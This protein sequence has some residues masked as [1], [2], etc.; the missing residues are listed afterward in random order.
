MICVLLY[1]TSGSFFKSLGWF[2]KIYESVMLVLVF[3]LVFHFFKK[4]GFKVSPNP[5][6][7]FWFFAFFVI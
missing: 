1:A 2:L 4:I 7:R 3:S 5:F 6:S